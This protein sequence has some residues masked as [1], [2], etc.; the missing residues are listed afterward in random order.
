MKNYILILNQIELSSGKIK[1]PNFH[2]HF[3]PCFSSIILIFNMGL[4]EILFLC[5]TK[6][7]FQQKSLKLVTRK[8]T[9][10]IKKLELLVTAFHDVTK[11]LFVQAIYLT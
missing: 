5:L 3:P 2:L 6:K 8:I 11:R 10:K 7:L 1:V 9:I 4:I